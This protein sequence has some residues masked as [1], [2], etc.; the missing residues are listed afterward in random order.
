[1]HS[2]YVKGVVTRTHECDDL[3]W[4]CSERQPSC[5]SSHRYVYIGARAPD[6]KMRL[7]FFFNQYFPPRWESTNCHLNHMNKAGSVHLM[8]SMEWKLG[9]SAL[10]CKPIKSIQHCHK[11]AHTAFSRHCQ[12]IGSRGQR[13][14]LT[15]V[16]MWSSS[17]RKYCSHTGCQVNVVVSTLHPSLGAWALNIAN[18][19]LVQL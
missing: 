5:I 15:L 11:N 12:A 4:I 10:S 7:A 19:K 14:Q 16:R 17:H 9:I 1:M 13:S 2:Y 3:Y 6:I 8:Y 18:A